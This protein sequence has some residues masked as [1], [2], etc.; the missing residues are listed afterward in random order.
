[1]V[2]TLDPALLVGWH[3]LT[4]GTLWMS[5]E[6][7]LIESAIGQENSIAEVLTGEVILYGLV[8]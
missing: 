3:T 7:A 1:M 5:S 4:K 2:A 6:A 8:Q